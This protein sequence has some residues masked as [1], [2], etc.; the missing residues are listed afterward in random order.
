[1]VGGP[2]LLGPA[3][4]PARAP[5]HPA[6]FARR[7]SRHFSA[8]AS[9]IGPWILNVLPWPRLICHKWI[10]G[11]VLQK[12][13]SRARQQQRVKVMAGIPTWRPCIASRMKAVVYSF[14]RP[15]SKKHRQ[16][17]KNGR[18]HN[19]ILTG[20]RSPPIHEA[21]CRCWSRAGDGSGDP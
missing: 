14:P 18:I 2:R 12:P 8:A 20:F 10:S 1:M 17:G 21:P 11:P 3:V 16:P 4:F 5:R 9:G 19:G 6:F 15:R 13:S 7:G